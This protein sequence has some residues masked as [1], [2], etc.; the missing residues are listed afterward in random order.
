MLT[1]TIGIGFGYSVGIQSRGKVAGKPRICIS[2]NTKSLPLFAR[3]RSYVVIRDFP[4]GYKLFLRYGEGDSNPLQYS[5]LENP[6]GRGAWWAAVH[7][8]TESDTTDATLHAYMHGSGRS[9]VQGNGNTL[10]YSC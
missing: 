1:V 3:N 2:N 8:V 9:P 4:G 7:R 6:V 10:Q 5:C